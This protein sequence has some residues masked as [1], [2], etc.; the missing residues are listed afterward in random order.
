MT[1]SKP[2]SDVD[3]G[4]LIIVTISG[5]SGLE[6]CFYI[7][8]TSLYWRRKRSKEKNDKNNN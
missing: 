1:G 8:C 2:S 4:S 6:P 7:L 3:L 5:H